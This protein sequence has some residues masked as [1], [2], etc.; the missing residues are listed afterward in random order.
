M[1]LTGVLNG[2]VGVSSRY[3]SSCRVVTYDEIM[4]V[5]FGAVCRLDWGIVR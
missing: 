3:R 4:M 2:Y 1:S 5:V